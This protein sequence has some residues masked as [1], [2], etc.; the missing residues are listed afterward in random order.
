M[1]RNKLMVNDMNAVF[2]F[3]EGK[4]Y[5]VYVF[6]VLNAEAGS[7]NGVVLRCFSKLTQWVS[8]QILCC[9][10]NTAGYPPSPVPLFPSHARSCFCSNFHPRAHV[11]TYFRFATAHFQTWLSRRDLPPWLGLE[12][13][14]WYRTF[15][16]T[17]RRT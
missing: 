9:F 13:R 8:C 16:N 3:D 15:V 12:A 14:H 10:F 1:K 11:T 4:L 5:H 6:N 2:C 17:V 7:L